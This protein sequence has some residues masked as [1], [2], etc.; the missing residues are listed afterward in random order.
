[1]ATITIEGETYSVD[2]ECKGADERALVQ[3]VSEL[4]TRHAHLSQF[5]TVGRIVLEY[6]RKA[7]E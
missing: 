1:M 4:L 7:G 3:W 2:I 5:V 6:P